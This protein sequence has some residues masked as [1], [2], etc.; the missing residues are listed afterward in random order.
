MSGSCTCTTSNCCSRMKA[1]TRQGDTNSPTRLSEPL[2]GKLATPGKTTTPR[3]RSFRLDGPM[4]VTSSPRSRSTRASW[5]AWCLTPPFSLKSYGTTWQILSGRS[6]SPSGPVGRPSKVGSFR[7]RRFCKV[8]TKSPTDA[9]F[10]SSFP[11]ENNPPADLG[12]LL[13]DCLRQQARVA[14]SCRT[15]DRA[16]RDADDPAALASRA[17]GAL[18]QVHAKARLDGVLAY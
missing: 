10:R 3:S 5:K 1:P 11:Q 14:G 15:S 2:D 17:V 4:M 8:T 9:A 16:F 13:D 7:T 12:Q 18:D 6:T